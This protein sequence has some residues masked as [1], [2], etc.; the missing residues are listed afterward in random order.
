MFMTGDTGTQGV[1]RPLTPPFQPTKEKETTE[2]SGHTVRKTPPPHSASEQESE[3]ISQVAQQHLLQAQSEL[4]HPKVVEQQA[5]VQ[6]STFTERERARL[7]KVM[8]DASL[9]LKM[10]EGEIRKMVLDPSRFPLIKTAFEAKIARIGNPEEKEDP[11][12]GEILDPFPS[13]V[14]DLTLRE[15]MLLGTIATIIGKTEVLDRLCQVKP[16]EVEMVTIDPAGR[17]LEIKRFGEKKVGVPC[18]LMEGGIGERAGVWE[19]TKELLPLDAYGLSYSRAGYGYSDSCP[20]AGSLQRSLDDFSALVSKLEKEGKTQPPY[21]L[22]GH[23]LGGM[24]M[25]A[26]AKSHLDTVKGLVLVE[27]TIDEQPPEPPLSFNSFHPELM[28]RKTEELL[29]PGSRDQATV[30]T[31]VNAMC[32]FSPLS[33]GCDVIKGS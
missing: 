26:Y 24:L 9:I 12:F 15:R 19:R 23:S 3:K 30:F 5:K 18:I 11:S 8:H 29:L 7:D 28:P 20:D 22:V 4:V 21:V 10:D 32:E 31:E 25:Q 13:V 1:Q 16:T 27:S 14:A 17:Q 2:M 6:I 33:P